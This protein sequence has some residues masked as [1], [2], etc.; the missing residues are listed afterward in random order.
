MIGRVHLD[1][2][3]GTA[4]SPAARAALLDA[5][6]LTGNPSSLHAS[7]R[8]ARR[9]LEESRESLAASLGAHPTE[10]VL[11]S[12]GTEA[13][14]LALRG[15]WLARRAGGRDAVA[16][17]AV[18]HPAVL[19][20]AAALRAEGAAV[21]ELAVG[22]D[23]TVREEAWAGLDQRVAVASVM[24]VN[25]ETGT[26]QPVDRL[27]EA[28]RRVGAWSHSDAVQAVGVEDVGFAASGLDLLSV[29]GHKLGAPVGIGA[30]LVRREVGLQPVAWGG[31]QE[32]DL[33]SGTVPVALAAAL[34]AACADVVAARVR[35]TAALTGLRTRLLDGLAASGLGG[36]HVH[37]GPRT[38]PAIVMLGFD[39]LRADDLLML[40]DAAGVDCSTGSACSAGVVGPSPVLLATGLDEAA[41]SAAVR[42]SFG[43]TSSG[44]DVDAL[45]TA[46]PDAVARA[47]AVHG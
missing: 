3:A 6:E 29:S 14:N 45:L 16:V 38:S 23:A 31:G 21:V 11:T 37:G 22:A 36:V 42:F 10:V 33:R 44:S 43:A 5:L 41:A 7:G 19:E 28:A 39:G 46:L 32:R 25:N 27:V 2:A 9:V 12:G 18:E 1:H 8:V 40:L 30:L 34:A 47:R 26:V 24:W 20:T 17:S 15:S 35:R 4:V 13:D